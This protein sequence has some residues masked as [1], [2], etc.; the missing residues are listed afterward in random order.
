MHRLVN[1]ANAKGCL[2][3]SAAEG[4]DRMLYDWLKR[5]LP[6]LAQL[7]KKVVEHLRKSHPLIAEKGVSFTDLLRGQD[8]C[9]TSAGI[10]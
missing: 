5:Q 2:P 3:P 9:C 1:Y 6:A 7:P 8:R 4:S 10:I